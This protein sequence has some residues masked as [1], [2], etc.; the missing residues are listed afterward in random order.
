MASS[1]S[2][3][4]KL[5]PE[6]AL[7]ADQDLPEDQWPSIAD[8]GNSLSGPD[9][10]RNVEVSV[11]AESDQEG[12]KSQQSPDVADQDVQLLLGELRF[13]DEE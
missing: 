9:E 10:G 3:S 13:S 1:T 11:K 2:L 5:E 8:S 6:H 12:I 7:M 4:L